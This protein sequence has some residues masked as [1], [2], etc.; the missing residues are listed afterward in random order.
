M[1]FCLLALVAF[2]LNSC[3]T[4]SQ[5]AR[6]PSAIDFHES[7]RLEL[8]SKLKTDRHLQV[9]TDHPSGKS[10]VFGT[11]L[12]R[13][14]FPAALGGLSQ[15]SDAFQIFE[16]STLERETDSQKDWT[17]SCHAHPDACSEHMKQ[18]CETQSAKGGETSAAKLIRVLQKKGFQLKEIEKNLD[19]HPTPLCEKRDWWIGKCDVSPLVQ[20]FY[21]NPPQA[22]KVDGVELNSEDLETAAYAIFSQL[23]KMKAIQNELNP[24]DLLTILSN[25]YGKRPEKYL[26]VAHGDSSA[27]VWNALIESYQ[28]ISVTEVPESES[29]KFYGKAARFL[30]V[31]FELQYATEDEPESFSAMVGASGTGE[32]MGGA[33]LQA[34]HPT[35][36]WTFSTDP[37]SLARALKKAPRVVRALF[38]AVLN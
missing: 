25:T 29:A 23:G 7:N 36:L 3:V 38:D 37:Q 27:Q 1:R 10:A 18:V 4:H 26:I 8:I 15:T 6:S 31:K 30:K 17:D 2:V 33:W 11:W 5:I 9:L 28:I 16:D 13:D 20:G 32:M 12:Q 22:K 24:A 21:P 14:A 35:S 19:L 34:E